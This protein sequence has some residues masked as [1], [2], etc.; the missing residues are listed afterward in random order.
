MTKRPR[1]Q[2]PTSAAPSSVPAWPR[3]PT[4][5]SRFTPLEI[6]KVA[7]HLLTIAS[8]FP[9]DIAQLWSSYMATEIDYTPPRAPQKGEATRTNYR[10]A[11]DD[12]TLVH[13]LWHET[14]LKELCESEGELHVVGKRMVGLNSN[15]RLYKYGVGSYFGSE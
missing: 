12:P 2:P 11:I 4:L 1:L 6:T 9:S 7:P 3:L 8:F 15:L 5:A 10:F 13:R 14:G